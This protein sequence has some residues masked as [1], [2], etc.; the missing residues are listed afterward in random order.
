[1]SCRVFYKCYKGLVV[2]QFCAS[3]TL[4]SHHVYQV[5]VV[6]SYQWSFSECPLRVCHWAYESACLLR[7]LLSCLVEDE[8]LP[9]V[10][11]LRACLSLDTS[12]FLLSEAMLRSLRNELSVHMDQ[13]EETAQFEENFLFVQNVLLLLR[14]IC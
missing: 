12:E 8:D 13:F 6:A 1:M 2:L 11:D 7:T 14:E 4:L 3:P 10:T 5:S 9:L